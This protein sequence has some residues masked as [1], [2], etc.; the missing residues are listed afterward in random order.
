VAVDEVVVGDED[1]E[2]STADAEHYAAVPATDNTPDAEEPAFSEEPGGDGLRKE[3]ETKAQIIDDGHDDE[4]Y[5]VLRSSASLEEAEPPEVEATDGSRDQEGP[6]SGVVIAATD[7]AAVDVPAPPSLERAASVDDV[8]DLPTN[9]KSRRGHRRR[10]RRDRQHPPSS[11][12]D[13]THLE[14]VEALG[15]DSEQAANNDDGVDDSTAGGTGVTIAI[16]EPPDEGSS[17]VQSPSLKKDAAGEVP[18]GADGSMVSDNPLVA[19]ASKAEV[20]AAGEPVEE[21]GIRRWLDGIKNGYGDRF[22]PIF[23]QGGGMH[24]VQDL[25]AADAGQVDRVM[26]ALKEDG[27]KLPTR[28][29]IKAGIMALLP[30]GDGEA[31]LPP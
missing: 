18:G 3:E 16:G 10:H 15:D 28:R 27:C 8:D 19:S 30:A 6:S 11:A 14:V 9:S 29:R 21:R 24:A 20:G 2:L 5:N 22:G 4:V 31:D 26:R 23:E 13:E 25:M 7:D 17:D 12:T 1:V